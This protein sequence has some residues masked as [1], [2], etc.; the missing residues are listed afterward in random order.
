MA[1]S[2]VYAP[3]PTTQNMLGVEGS[4]YGAVSV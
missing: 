4:V 1:A 3:A 2:T